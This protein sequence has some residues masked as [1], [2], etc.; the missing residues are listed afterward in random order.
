MGCSPRRPRR[1]SNGWNR[2]GGNPDSHLTTALRDASNRDAGF[3][4][5]D[6]RGRVAGRGRLLN[7]VDA[8]VPAVGPVRVRGLCG[9]SIVGPV[10]GLTLVGRLVEAARQA[11][12]Q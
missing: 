5:V 2:T 3:V 1:L 11:E 12:Q 10:A 7:D 8:G 4:P 6:P 9:G